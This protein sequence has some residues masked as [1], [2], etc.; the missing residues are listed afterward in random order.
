VMSNGDFGR[1]ANSFLRRIYSLRKTYPTPG[2]RCWRG[3]RVS[4][5][6]ESLATSLRIY[7]VNRDRCNPRASLHSTPRPW[8]T[9]TYLSRSQVKGA[10]RW[11][12]RCRAA[13]GG[14]R[15]AS[16]VQIVCAA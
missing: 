4:G 5:R 11:R 13:G 10:T 6:N 1:S 14:C 8:Q 16:R 7:A 2:R 9:E 3:Q 15:I 12:N